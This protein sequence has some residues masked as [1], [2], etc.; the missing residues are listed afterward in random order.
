[1]GTH[2]ITINVGTYVTNMAEERVSDTVDFFPK[3]C[4]LPLLS[5]KSLATK[6]SIEISD[7][8]DNPLPEP[9]FLAPIIEYLKALE[10]LVEIFKKAAAA[11]RTDGTY[12]RVPT[13]YRTP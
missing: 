2:Q 7:V 12:P 6:A 10:M 1:M 11:Q 8:R 3:Q 13:S 5:S 9:P 4:Q